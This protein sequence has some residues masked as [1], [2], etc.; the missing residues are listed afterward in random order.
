[1]ALICGNKL[2]EYI[3]TELSNSQKRN[4]EELQKLAIAGTLKSQKIKEISKSLYQGKVYDIQVSNTNCYQLNGVFS[5]NS[6]GG[7]LVCYLLGIHS[8]NPIEWDLSFDRFL[9]PSRGGYN[10]NLE[11]PEP[12]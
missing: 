1:M 7:S 6:A 3:M 10:L 11:M 2:G 5:S 4:I 8:L 12:V 9:S